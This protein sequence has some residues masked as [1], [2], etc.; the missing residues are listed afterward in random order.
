[1][2]STEN[3][4]YVIKRKT[5]EKSSLIKREKNITQRQ[6]DMENEEKDDKY[7]HLYYI[8][9]FNIYKPL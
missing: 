7:M 4:K 8:Y 5:D 3:D 1:M 9:I 2:R 6:I